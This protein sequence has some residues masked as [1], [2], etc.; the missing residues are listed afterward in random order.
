MFLKSRLS[1]LIPTINFVLK[2]PGMKVLLRIDDDTFVNVPGFLDYWHKNF[3]GSDD[4]ILCESKLKAPVQRSGQW[5]VT[6]EEYAGDMFDFPHC[7][8]WFAAIS[9]NLITK[10]HAE[11]RKLPFFWID[12]V[13]MYGMVPK[14]IG[15]VKFPSG[16]N[17]FLKDGENEYRLCLVAN[18]RG[19][20]WLASIARPIL[21]DR[22]LAWKDR[23]PCPTLLGH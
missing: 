10:M 22:L 2:F 14:A 17:I 20:H 9:P 13:F 16:K 23:C 1:T 15:N 11:A 21:F 12:D 3:E 5:A 7:F 8:G 18:G 6:A 4:V 19:C